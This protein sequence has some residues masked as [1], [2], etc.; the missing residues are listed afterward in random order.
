MLET[1]I[2]DLNIMWTK[3]S[4]SADGIWPVDHMFVNSGL[5]NH[6]ST[7]YFWHILKKLYRNHF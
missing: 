4:T 3:Q 5:D 7:Y 1:N 6:I 2:K